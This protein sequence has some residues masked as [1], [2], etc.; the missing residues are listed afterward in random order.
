MIHFALDG[1]TSFSSKPLRIAAYSGIIVSLV[2]LFYALYAII[3]HFRGDTI[4]GWTSLLIT[5]LVLG[6]VQLLSLGIIGEYISRIFNESKS[7][8]LYFI[9]NTTPLSHLDNEKPTTPQKNQ[10]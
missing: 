4:Q 6:G 1:V 9:K 8:P 3:R 10:K 2:G 5:V 7:R